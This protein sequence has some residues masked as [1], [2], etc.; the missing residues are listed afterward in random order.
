MADT[1]LF[2]DSLLDA[3][4]LQDISGGPSNKVSAE[5][6]FFSKSNLELLNKEERLNG[7][8]FLRREDGAKRVFRQSTS[9]LTDCEFSETS[10]ENGTERYS[11]DSCLMRCDYNN[12][13]GNMAIDMDTKPVMNKKRGAMNQNV[14]DQPQSQPVDQSQSSFVP[15]KRHCVPVDYYAVDD[16][17]IGVGINIEEDESDDMA[18]NFFPVLS[19]Q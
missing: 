14:Q 13:I 2:F 19:S 9:T 16:Y 3:F 18:R 1:G 4:D 5:Y 10:G 15:R 8:N 11:E 6:S 17:D 12:S 7:R